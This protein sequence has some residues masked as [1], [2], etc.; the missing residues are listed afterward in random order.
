MPQTFESKFG[1]YAIFLLLL[2][3]GALIFAYIILVLSLILPLQ[4]SLGDFGKYLGFFLILSFLGFIFFQFLR[5]LLT[6][7]TLILKENSILISDGKTQTEINWQDIYS[8]SE[9]LGRN[10]QLFSFRMYRIELNTKS[11]IFYLPNKILSNL[12]HTTQI[13][14][15]LKNKKEL[16]NKL[17]LDESLWQMNKI[18]GYVAFLALGILLVL[19]I[20]SFIYSKLNG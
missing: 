19:L 4:S 13:R 5:F 10:N 16:Q 9:F 12:N 11:G 18:G 6:K 14:N 2:T 17:N 7:E 3:L 20:S 1:F 8:I 15:F